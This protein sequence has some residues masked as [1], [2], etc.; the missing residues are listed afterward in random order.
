MTRIHSS[1][2]AAAVAVLLGACTTTPATIDELE[3][4]RAVVPQVENSPRAGVAALEIG[5]AR[6]ALDRANT[7]ADKR[8]K[9]GDVQYEASVATKYAQI[10]NEKILTAQARDE[11]QKGESERQAVLVSAREREANRSSQQ[12]QAASAQAQSAEERAKAFEALWLRL[13]LSVDWSMTYATIS[14][15]AQKVSQLAFLHLLQRGL[16]YQL[17]APTLWDI[18][19][20]TAVAQ[21]E[22]EDREQP[23]AYHRIR[24]GRAGR[25]RR[26][27]RHDAARADPGLRGAGRASRG[28]ALSRPRRTAGDARRSSASRCRSS[29]TRWPTPRRVPASR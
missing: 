20:R 17:E 1:I 24:F 8:G 16:A 21:A 26:R 5:E 28:R 18:D 14:K 11:I 23:G 22:L 27:D 6:K 9:L 2:L 13:G 7:L 12:A 15:R 3:T 25:R 29:P 10:A 4:A 19:F